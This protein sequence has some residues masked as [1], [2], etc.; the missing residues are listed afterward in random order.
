M[1]FKPGDR[2]RF[3]R[4]DR[5]ERT[6]T[7]TIRKMYPAY[8]EIYE[9]ERVTSDEAAEVVPDTLPDWWPY[10]DCDSFAPSTSELVPICHGHGSDLIGG[11]CPDCIIEAGD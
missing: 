2:V 1:T 3:T 11:K 10:P 5:P 4:A 9:G 6:L 8:D 7:G